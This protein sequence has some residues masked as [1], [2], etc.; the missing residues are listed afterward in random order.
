MGAFGQS[1]FDVRFEWGAEGAAALAPTSEIVVVVDV[2]SFCTAVDIAVARGASVFPFL[3]RDN[4]AAHF[5]RQARAALAVDRRH[6]TPETPFS[7]SPGSLRSIPPGTGLVLPSPNGAAVTLAAA[8]GGTAVMAGCLRN[9]AAVA[10]TCHPY[11][12]VGVVAAGE[13]WGD[14]SLRPAVED[15]IGAGAIITHLL[16]RE[17]SPEARAALGAFRSVRPAVHLHSCSSGRELIE[18][19]FGE[20]VTL[21]AQCDVSAVVPILREGAYVAR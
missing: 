5:A 16:D 18:A 15:L 14:G 6:T 9:A 7:L 13:R 2:L 17:L 1:G 19:G 4:R 11:A 3:W 20:D 8:R 21:A 12:T 10:R